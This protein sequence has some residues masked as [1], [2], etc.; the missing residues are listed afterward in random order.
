MRIQAR[1]VN[2]EMKVFSRYDF[3]FLTLI[4]IQ[5]EDVWGYPTL[6]TKGHSN[7]NILGADNQFVWR[8]KTSNSKKRTSRSPPRSQSII[9]LVD[10]FLRRYSLRALP[11]WA[12]CS[13]LWVHRTDLF[14]GFLRRC[15][16][17]IC[18]GRSRE[19]SSCFD[20]GY[21]SSISDATGLVYLC[22][23]KI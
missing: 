16:V 17:L 5:G 6:P 19:S 20:Y 21:E 10:L 9:A 2:E 4:S 7:V 8:N 1:L 13:Q 23:R 3:F 11:S 22:V 18:V 12:G 15:V 14:S